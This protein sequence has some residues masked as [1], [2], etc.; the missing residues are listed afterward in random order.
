MMP[1][2]IRV[3]P[4][5]IINSSRYIFEFSFQALS[6]FDDMI[7]IITYNFYKLLFIFS[8]AKPFFTVSIAKSQIIAWIKVKIN[9]DIQVASFVPRRR[10]K[11]DH[12][13]IPSAIV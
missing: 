10:L 1:G 6:F 4:F 5:D 9:A 3:S 7:T 12:Y 8:A 2:I 13:N 11:F